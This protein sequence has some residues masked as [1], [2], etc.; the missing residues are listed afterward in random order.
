MSKNLDNKL[1]GKPSAGSGDTKTI[2]A[3]T[4]Q[5]SDF[6]SLATMPKGVCELYE[7]ST[8]TLLKLGT[9]RMMTISEFIQYTILSFIE[10]T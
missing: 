8:Q 7:S 10:L 5:T 1:K 2:R 4:R 6:T 9:W 3:K